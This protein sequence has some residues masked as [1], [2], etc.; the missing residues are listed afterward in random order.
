MFVILSVAWLADL[1]KC[2]TWIEFGCQGKVGPYSIYD[3]GS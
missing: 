1:N 2:N 3:F